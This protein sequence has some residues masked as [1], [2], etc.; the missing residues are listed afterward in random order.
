M[1]EIKISELANYC[2]SIEVDCSICENKDAC[3]AFSEKIEDISPKGLMEL[4]NVD[5]T[6]TYGY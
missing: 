6:I 2:K 1:E 4:V 5:K 3:D